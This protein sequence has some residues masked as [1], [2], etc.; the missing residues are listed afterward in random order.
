MTSEII[1]SIIGLSI[2][3]IFGFIGIYLTVKSKY[4]GKIT[5]VNEQ[6]IELFDA[7]G[8]SLD[9]LSVTYNGSAVNENLI[10]LNGA[11]INSGKSDITSSMVEQPITIR[12]PD[13]YK[14]LTGKVIK[15]NAKANLIQENENT[16][17]ISTGLFR[18]G[19]YVRFHAL[20]Q[21]PEA[22]EDDSSSK[23]FKRALS[24]N[25][26]IV[27]TKNI[28]ETVTQPQKTSRKN[29]ILKGFFYLVILLMLLGTISLVLFEGLPKIMLYSYSIS[30]SRVEQVKITRKRNDFVKVES[31]ESEFEVEEP[32][33]EFISKTTG[34]PT[35]GESEDSF[36]TYI[37]FFLLSSYALLVLGAFS[38]HSFTFYRNRRILKILGEADSN[39]KASAR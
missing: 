7:I 36:K 9:K 35:L 3:A 27:N 38:S 18:C 30:D 21:L 5:F 13:G 19:E 32:F 10:L 15:S 37:L 4:S 8:N 34:N 6:T 12:L 23:R 28:E 16:M 20:A 29:F 31:K 14:W 24:F 11:F 33:S 26:R 22:D 17:S 39:A 2:S 1:F 25:H